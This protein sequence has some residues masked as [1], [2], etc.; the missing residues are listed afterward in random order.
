MKKLSTSII[1]LAGMLTASISQG[2]TTGSILGFAGQATGSITVTS[3]N[4]GGCP[5]RVC[6]TNGISTNVFCFTNTFSKV[7]CTTNAAGA[8][9]CTNVVVTEERCFTNIFPEIRCTNEFVGPT[10]LSLHET[11]TGALAESACD[12]VSALFPSN[13]VIQA[14]LV[15]S[16]RT[17]DWAGT[18]VGF[19]KILDGT[20]VLAAGSMTGVNGV[21]CG[22]CNQFGGILHGT[23]LASGPL[24]G[25]SLQAEYAG[26]LTGVT[27]PSAAIPQGAVAL[28]IDGVAVVP[29]LSE[30]ER[31]PTA[32]AGQAL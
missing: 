1:A 6:T 24:R 10:T 2:Q 20:N 18:Q 14:S 3:T 4:L 19:F 26:S 15:V 32:V 23:V 9:D 25:A 22:S 30:F 12:Q 27:C 11:L 8:V 13:A 17:N 16:V 29:C 5:T 7:V 21:P 31:M 28:T